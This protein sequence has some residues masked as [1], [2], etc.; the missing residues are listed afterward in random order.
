MKS[1][2]KLIWISTSRL[3]KKKKRKEKRKTN[4]K[5]LIPLFL[6][7]CTNIPLQNQEREIYSYLDKNNAN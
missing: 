7:M 5:Q 3:K 2:P 1:K 4:S 6:S